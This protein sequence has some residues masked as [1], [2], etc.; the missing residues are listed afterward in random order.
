L[1]ALIDNAVQGAQRG[2]TLTKGMLAFAR[3]QELKQE[4][5]NIPDLVRG[6]TDLLQRS[7]GPSVAI[8]THFPLGITDALADPAQLE[9]AVLNLMF[10]ARDAMPEGGR[11]SMSARE[12]TVGAGH[13]TRLTPGA[14]IVF[15]V[16]DRRVGMDE[17]TLKQ[18]VEP[19]FTTKGLGKGT[20]LGLPMVCRRAIGRALSPAQ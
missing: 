18:A 16:T 7:L 14:Y 5:V 20:G 3:R 12:E 15:A 13:L 1:H 10:N 8:D 4:P 17:K 11:I 9:M 19:F 2:A 6:M